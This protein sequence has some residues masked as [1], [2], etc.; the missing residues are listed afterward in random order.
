MPSARPWPRRRSASARPGGKTGTARRLHDAFLA[1]RE[2]PFVTLMA[3]RAAG[4]GKV[5]ALN[6]VW[7]TR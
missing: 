4:D 7:S 6:K 2:E 1:I 5:H 3:N